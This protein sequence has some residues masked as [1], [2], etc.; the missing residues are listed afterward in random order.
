[1]PTDPDH[2][3]RT[4]ATCDRVAD[5]YAAHIADEL[6]GKPLDRALLACFAELVDG[7]GAIADIGCGPGH[8]AEYLHGLG[9]QVIG[10]D[11]SPEMVALARKRAPDVP[12]ET[13]SMLALA[14]PDATWGG[15]VA[16]Y[17][18][19]HLPP[20]ARPLALAEFHR[21][22]RPG[23]LLLLAFHI[24]DIADVGDVGEEQRHLDEWWG[25]AVSLDVWFLQP[26]EIEATLRAVGFTIEMSLV[27]QPYAPEVEHQSQRAYILARKPAK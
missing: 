15:I 24:G 25:Q 6:A 1:M 18:I 20:E 8:V 12:F 27:R 11:L 16:F 4:R 22:L 10:I 2:L 7:A 14:V 3:T 26:A 19:I 5:E 9:A 17:S 23:G 21:A 13:G